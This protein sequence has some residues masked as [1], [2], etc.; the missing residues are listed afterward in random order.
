MFICN[1]VRAEQEENSRAVRV[2]LQVFPEA[3]AA[4]QYQVQRLV[5]FG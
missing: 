5:K 2:I 1:N 3:I 4:V